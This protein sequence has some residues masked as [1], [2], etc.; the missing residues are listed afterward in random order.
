MKAYGLQDNMYHHFNELQDVH[1]G[2]W[3][4][5]CG[6]SRWLSVRLDTIISLYIASVAIMMVPLSQSP[7]LSGLLSLTPSAIGLSLSQAATMLGSIQWAVRQSSEAE[8]YLTSVERIFEYAAMTPEPELAR[9]DI[10]DGDEKSIGSNGKKN[11]DNNGDNFDFD[12]KTVK[13]RT[14]EIIQRSDVQHKNFA[15]NDV[16]AKEFNFSYS[17]N[18]GLVLKDLNF[19][20][21]I[22]EKI[23]I[24]GRTGAGKSSL[25]SAFF[26]MKNAYSGMSSMI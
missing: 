16:V 26:R 12:R 2:A 5:F 22:G 4:L 19:D 17:S 14:A 11:G 1:G 7:E 23:G 20:I 15:E 25:I 10:T 21:K 6:T 8:N 3:L 13:A 9:D 18:T 24:V